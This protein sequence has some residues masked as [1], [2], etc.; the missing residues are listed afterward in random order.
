MTALT[1]ASRTAMAMLGT[2]SSSKPARSAN[3]CAVCSTLSTLSIEEPSVRDTRLV[4]ESG[5]LVPLAGSD[6][7]PQSGCSD[8]RSLLVD[9]SN[10]KGLGVYTGNMGVEVGDGERQMR[11]EAVA[12]QPAGI[13][14]G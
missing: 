8:D 4:V 1:A 11:F 5:N 6:R 14:C 3:S 7:L 13:G 9:D 10:V 12:A 2:V